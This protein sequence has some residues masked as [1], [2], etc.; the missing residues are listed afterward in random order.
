MSLCSCLS[1]TWICFFS[2]TNVNWVSLGFHLASWQDYIPATILHAPYRMD[3]SD[4]VDP[5]VFPLGD[6]TTPIS[7]NIQSD[8]ITF[9][10]IQLPLALAATL[11]VVKTN[12]TMKS[13]FLVC[14]ILCTS[15]FYYPL[16]NTASQLTWLIPKA[17][18]WR[19]K[20]R[21]SF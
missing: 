11:I 3:L 8:E 18:L 5:L 1:E 12:I 15:I 20:H 17:N 21:D 4:S 16:Q 2:Y 9:F 14:R 6:Q 7:L 19:S 13:I 10:Y